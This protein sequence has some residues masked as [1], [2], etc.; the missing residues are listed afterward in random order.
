MQRARFE[1]ALLT[2]A[3]Y[4]IDFPAFFDFRGRI[5]RTGMLHFH[6]R[7]LAKS[8]ISFPYGEKSNLLVGGKHASPVSRWLVE[9]AV[10]LHHHSFDTREK[11]SDWTRSIVERV[12]KLE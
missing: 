8:L 7:D 10:G 4:D 9:Q 3:G 11:A 1:Q 12:E 6:E 2:R 5:S